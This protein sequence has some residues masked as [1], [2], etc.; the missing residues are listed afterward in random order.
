MSGCGRITKNV[1]CILM[2]SPQMEVTGTV[3]VTGRD[4]PYKSLRRVYLNHPFSKTT[5][6]RINHG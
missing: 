5:W 1:W 3:F 6:P 2:Y 4:E